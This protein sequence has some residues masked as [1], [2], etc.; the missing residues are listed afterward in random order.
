[1]EFVTLIREFRKKRKVPKLARGEVREAPASILSK[2]TLSTHSKSIKSVRYKNTEITPAVPINPMFV[3]LVRKPLPVK[4]EKTFQTTARLDVRGN[5]PVMRA[6]TLRRRG[7]DGLVRSAAILWLISAAVPSALANYA[8]VEISGGNT[9]T[10]AEVFESPSPAPTASPSV[11]P[12]P[13]PVG[14]A[15]HLVISEVQINGG[16][17][18]EDFVELYNPTDTPIN[19]LNGW[20]IRIRNSTGSESSLVAITSGSIPAHGFFLWANDQGS[21]GGFAASIGA[22]VSNS[23]NLSPNSSIV[24]RQGTTIVDQL[25]WGTGSG[26]Q[27]GEGTV[28]TPNPG[29]HDGLE[30]KALTSSTASSMESGGSHEFKGNGFDSN[31]NAADFVLRD[32]SQPQNSG[33]ATEAL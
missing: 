29:N 7:M 20:N 23:N 33:S 8:D 5:A 9:F 17:A 6:G 27:F 12:L 28:F 3:P 4:K 24:L 10:V 21:G 31:N 30:R 22:D 32:V 2:N 1:M 16:D 14:I 13:T 11:S 25:A 18:N 26:S 15:D 19:N